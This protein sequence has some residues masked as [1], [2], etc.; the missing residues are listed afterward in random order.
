MF[1]APK[2]RLRQCESSGLRAVVNSIRVAWRA[3][4]KP[5]RT[6]VASEM[7]KA[8]PSTRESKLASTASEMPNGFSKPER[9][10]TVHLATTKPATPPMMANNRLSVSNWRMR[11]PCPAPNASRTAIS[12]WRFDACASRRFARLKHAISKTNPTTTISKPR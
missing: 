10:W 8:N 3:G 5:N 1:R 12:F 4:N 7:S 6:P 11:R 2:R 9:N